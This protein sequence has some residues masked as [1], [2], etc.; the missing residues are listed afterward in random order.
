MKMSVPD[1]HF[2]DQELIILANRELQRVNDDLEAQI[3]EDG[4]FIDRIVEL[5][6]KN[7]ALSEEV[8]RLK[9]VVKQWERAHDAQRDR[10]DRAE[11]TTSQNYVLRL[12]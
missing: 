12:P 5:E 7:A 4:G 11:R 6:E 2:G 10:A 8:V 3:H 1:T 9:D